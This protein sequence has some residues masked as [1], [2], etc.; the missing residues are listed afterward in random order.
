MGGIN[1]IMKIVSFCLNRKVTTLMIY[2]GVVII[3]LISWYFLPQELFPPLVYPQITVLT[4]YR[5]ASPYE[6]ESMITRPIEEAIGTVNRLKRISS[7]SRE[8]ASI[9]M[10]EF[11]W[12]T[13]MDFAALE[14]REKLDL[15][16]E[17]LPRE[18]EEPIVMKHNPFEMPMMRINIIGEDNPL[19]LRKIAKKNVKEELEK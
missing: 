17:K 12:G 3:G 14:V 19:K 11:D 9:V 6:I 4:R 16:K 10:G 13:N 18:C 1:D 15:I 8:G 2:L 5:Q 7:I